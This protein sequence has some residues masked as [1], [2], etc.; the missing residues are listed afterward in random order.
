MCAIYYIFESSDLINGIKFKIKVF[1]HTEVLFVFV[2]R[3]PFV[4][5]LVYLKFYHQFNLL[6]LCLKGKVQVS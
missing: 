1:G 6:S 5:Q 2:S 4:P 3:V